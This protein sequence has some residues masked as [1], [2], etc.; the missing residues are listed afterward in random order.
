MIA[1]LPGFQEYQFVVAGV[2]NLD[3]NYYRHFERN[4]IRF[5][6]EQTFDLLSH[7]T[8]ALVTSGTATLE[9]ALFGVP[10]IVC[11]RTS[12]LS[13]AIGKMVIKVPFISLV[14]LIAGRA[15]VKELI[16]N[17]FNAR[18]LLDELRT[19]LTDA[20]YMA[21]IKAG[22]AELREKLGQQQAAKKTAELMVKYLQAS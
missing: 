11:Y 18:N 14:N 3:P 20:E 12:S 6:F 19:L 17:D 8:A 21:R 1:I 13:Y 2:S 22:Y 16:Q 4:G 15:V 9:T 5:L 7:S 10:Q